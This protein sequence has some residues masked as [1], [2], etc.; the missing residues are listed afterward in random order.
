MPY[1]VKILVLRS[2]RW[3]KDSPKH[4]ELMLEI[5]KLLLLHLVGFSILLY[6][7]S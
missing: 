4:V 5:N 7:Y 1:A 3:T 2:W 6:P